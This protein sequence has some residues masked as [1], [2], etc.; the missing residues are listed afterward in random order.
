ME[1]RQKG[2]QFKILDPAV[3]SNIP[4]APNRIRLL[5]MSLVLSLGLAGGA[6]MLAETLDTSFH[7]ADELREFT[8][9][10]VLASVPRI[11]TEVD[12]R[13]RQWRFRLAAAGATLGLVLIAGVSYVV[14]HGNE[15]LVQ[16]LSRGGS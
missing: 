14:S 15:Q 8:I 16:M 5:V 2:E 6:L 1:Q 9:V 3:P 10:P 4:A 7:S 13:R 11:V 12:R